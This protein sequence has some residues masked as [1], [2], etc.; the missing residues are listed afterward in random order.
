MVQGHPDNKERHLCHALADAYAEGVERAGHHVERIELG[1][2]DIPFL[3]SQ[4]EQEH[5][6]VPPAIAGAQ[7]LM[8]RRRTSRL[9]LPAVA[10]RNAGAAEGFPGA[11]GA[12]GL[13]L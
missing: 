1:Q 9:R 8:K 2:M 13:C 12:A 7:A 10:G 6:A 3:T 11:D 4:R 5:G